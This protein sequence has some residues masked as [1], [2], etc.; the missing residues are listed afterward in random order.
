MYVLTFDMH[1]TT[2][3]SSGCH[4]AVVPLACLRLCWLTVPRPSSPHIARFSVLP[5][6]LH[7]LCKLSPSFGATCNLADT[8]PSHSPPS[9]CSISFVRARPA[10]IDARLHHCSIMSG[11]KIAVIYSSVSPG[12]RSADR[13]NGSADEML[14]RPTVTSA[15]WRRRSPIRLGLQAQRLIFTNFPRVSLHNAGLCSIIGPDG[16]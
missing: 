3:D 1:L 6:A 10:S 9:V 5:D 12:D 8:S 11:A 4:S 2:R 15:P 7:P 13:S 14:Y 16:R